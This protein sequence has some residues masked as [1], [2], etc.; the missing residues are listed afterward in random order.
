MVYGLMERVSFRVEEASLSDLK[1]VISINESVLPENYPYYFYELLYENFGKAFLIA[2]VGDKI[3]GY[4]M[5]RVENSFRFMGF[6]PGFQRIG[7]IVS[8]AVLPEYR[9][10][11]IGTELIIRALN[12]LKNDYKCRSVYLEVRVSNIG[13]INFYRRLG[14]KIDR[15]IKGYYKD[16]EDAYVMSKD[17]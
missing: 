10:M 3:V 5:C 6:K 16:G 12:S 17:L 8:I 1:D 11:G 14:F 9:R 15:V 7:H 4:I 2:R 13:A